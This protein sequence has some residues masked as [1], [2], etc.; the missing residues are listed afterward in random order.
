MRE[1][2]CESMEHDL[3][4]AKQKLKTLVVLFL[5]GMVIVNGLVLWY[6]RTFIFE[7][8]G[9]FAAF[10]TA[11]KLLDRGQGR[12]LRDQEAQ[13]EVQQEFASKVTI[14]Q[15]PL[16]YVRPAFEA[17]IFAPFA[18]LSYHAAY[19]SWVAVNVLLLFLFPFL[20]MPPGVPSRAQ[21]LLGTLSLSYVPVAIDL[22]HG[23]DVIV[24]LVILAMGL[25]RL[26]RRAEFQAGLWF[27]LALVK[28]HLMIPIM[29]ILAL[30]REAKI[31]AGFISGALALLGI[32]VSIVGWR[33]VALYPAYLRH[34]NALHNAGM[35]SPESMPNLRGM[36]TIVW[37][38][39][40]FPA[41]ANWM[42]VGIVLA[43]VGFVSYRWDN[44][45]GDLQSWDSG[46]SI[47]II[48][49][50]LTS[51]YA[52]SYDLILLLLPIFLLG[53]SFARKTE[54]RGWPG[55]IFFSAAGL[56]CTPLLW[57]IFFGV[58]SFYLMV[59]VL[60][61]LLISAVRAMKVL[62]TQAET[63]CER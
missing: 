12:Q 11:G 10:Y 22:L 43:G 38:T 59:P 52:Y 27:A 57:L 29:L 16:P 44:D 54:L 53:G 31:V 20:V 41:W 7:G 21:L 8:Y 40:P 58:G 62:R 14:R 60:L 28:F 37:G 30:R 50:L 34:L 45:S 9:D 24:V 1:L 46:F 2:N 18:V 4:K 39:N 5:G 51:Y 26:R 6:G 32:S 23:Q 63:P 61:L 48:T 49:T 42:L 47:A 25:S 55:V 36:L 3:T 17:V 33:G 13:W 35:A 19:L 56:L 15:K